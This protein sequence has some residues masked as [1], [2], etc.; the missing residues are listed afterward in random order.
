MSL[1]CP[2]FYIYDTCE[3]FGHTGLSIRENVIEQD[4]ILSR[5]FDLI[6]SIDT[7]PRAAQDASDNTVREMYWDDITEKPFQILA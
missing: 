3:L 2:Q 6:A 7:V 5:F 1:I 4:V